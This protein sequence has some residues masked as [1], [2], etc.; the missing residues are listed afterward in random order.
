MIDHKKVTAFLAAVGM[1]AIVILTGCGAEKKAAIDTTD[2]VTEILD[3]VTVEFDGRNGEGTAFV[4]VD[5]NGLETEMVGGEENV[6]DLDEMED[7]ASL[8]KYINAV[9][10]INLSIDK[11]YGLANG[12]QVTVSVSFDHTAAEA[13]GVVFGDTSS[14]V[15][16]VN[17]LKR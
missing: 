14:K 1:A 10:S 12:D 9:S 15:F 2:G 6:K 8:T 13:A 7:L 11:N 16:E 17:G 3:Y 5:Y 4:N